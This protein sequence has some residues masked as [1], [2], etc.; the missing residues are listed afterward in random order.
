MDS[1]PETLFEALTP[2]GFS[3][4]VYRA[5]WEL[6]VDFKHP[7]MN[8]READVKLALENPDEVRVSK[9]D[10][11]VFLFYSVRGLKRWVCAVTKRTEA[12]GFLIT[13]YPTDAIKEGVKIWPR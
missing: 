13:A 4:R 7:A 6:I 9:S 12:E 3:V 8:G 1:I 10:P 2:L 5:R 11:S